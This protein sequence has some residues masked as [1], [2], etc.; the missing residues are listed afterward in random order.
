MCTHICTPTESIYHSLTH[1]C[2]GLS[3]LGLDITCGISP[4]RNRSFLTAVINFL[5]LLSGG[6]PCRISSVYADLSPGVWSRTLVILS[7]TLIYVFLLISVSRSPIAPCNSYYLILEIYWLKSFLPWL[8]LSMVSS[9]NWFCNFFPLRW[10]I[11]LVLLT[12]L[13]RMV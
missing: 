13:L 12:W 5:Q 3:L 1:M 11:W 4:W 2:L 6:P 10:S 9:F 7:G 8:V